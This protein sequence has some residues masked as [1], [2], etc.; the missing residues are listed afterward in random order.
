MNPQLKEGRMAALGGWTARQ[1]A[2][3]GVRSDGEPMS[4]EE[5]AS[6]DP[7]PDCTCWAPN[8]AEPEDHDEDCPEHPDNYDIEGI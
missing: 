4:A 8:D 6:C 3:L 5:M 1:W 7:Y 2:E